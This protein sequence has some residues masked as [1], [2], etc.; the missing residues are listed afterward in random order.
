M[1]GSLLK[2]SVTIRGDSLYCPLALSID[3]YGNCLTDCWHCYLRRLNHTWGQDLKPADT[4]LLRKKL[5][6]GLSNK[7]PKTPLAWALSQR[8]TIRWGNKSDPFQKAE[9]EHRVAR[10]IF[11]IL[12]GLNW[13]FVIQTRFPSVLEEYDRYIKRAHDRGIIT[14]MPVIS[15]GLERDWS[16]FERERTDP[17]ELRLRLIEKWSRSGIPVGVNGEPFIPGFHTDDD[18]ENTLK[19]LKKYGVTRYNTYNFHF[20]AFVARRLNDIGVDIEKI[21][22]HNRD[23]QWKRIL[24]R[25]LDLAKKYDIILGCPDFVNSGLSWVEKANT[26]CGVDVPNPCTFNT[27]HFKKCLQQGKSS[28]EIF[29]LTYDGTGDIEMGKAIIEGSTTEFYTLKD[30]K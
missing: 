10:P 28:S 11:N 25:L 13:S 22:F 23:K 29:D 9:L 26:C 20:N 3:S 30:L 21:W 4:E 24:S 7:H 14:I 15:P 18:F 27:H 16:L 8:K 19:L 1:A 6:S 5:V 2:N 17:P 12:T